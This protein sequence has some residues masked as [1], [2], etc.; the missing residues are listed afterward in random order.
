[1]KKLLRTWIP[2]A[3]PLVQSLLVLDLKGLRNTF[4]LVRLKQEFG[5]VEIE[6]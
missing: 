6:I 2:A 5:L 4:L 3:K 1:M